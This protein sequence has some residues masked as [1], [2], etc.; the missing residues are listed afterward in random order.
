MTTQGYVDPTTPESILIRLLDEAME[1]KVAAGHLYVRCL[2]R[3]NDDENELILEMID[4]VTAE[5]DYRNR[6]KDE[7]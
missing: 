6:S 5:R 3:L 1:I 4:E 7:A 2:L